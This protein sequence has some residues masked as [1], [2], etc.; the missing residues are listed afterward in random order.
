MQFC[1]GLK[2]ASSTQQQQQQQALSRQEIA[3][4]CRR[5]STD[6]VAEGGGEVIK[7]VGY[8]R[9]VSCAPLDSPLTGTCLAV[10][11]RRRCT[12]EA[13]QQPLKKGLP[14]LRCA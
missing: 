14:C 5:R 4:V 1:R 12:L 8:Q 11:G 7:G 6:E 9:W 2:P 13:S 10:E 3:E